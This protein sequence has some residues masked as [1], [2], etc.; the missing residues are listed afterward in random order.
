[1]SPL[2]LEKERKQI[3]YMMDHGYIRQS[4]SPYGAQVLF[5]PKE[6]GSLRFC[7]DYRSFNKKT[8]LNR[9]FLPLPE[10]LYNRL[11]DSRIF[12]KIDLR[13]G[14]WKMLVR[15]EDIPETA[16]KTRWGLYDFLLLPFEVTNAPIQF[17][18]LMNDV[19]KEYL[20]KLVITFLDDILIYS[21]T[22]E[23]HVQHLRQILQ[24][25]KQYKLYAKAPNV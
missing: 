23:D 18:N 22:I 12:S 11:G 8:I 15:Y 21:Q 7:I 10:D 19:F 17:M 5:A 1:M 9:Y 20:D 25:L 2:E 6:D 13:L 16:F 3:Q 4:D 24:K 14:S